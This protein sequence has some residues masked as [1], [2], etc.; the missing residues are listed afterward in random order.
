MEVRAMERA[1]PDPR[2]L[3]VTL[4]ILEEIKQ[5]I[6]PGS[7]VSVVVDGY[8]FD[9]DYHRSLWE[10]GYKVLI[11]DDKMN[12]PF[13]YGHVILNQNLGAEQFTYPSPENTRALLGSPYALIRP[14]FL[15]YRNWSRETS[16]RANRVLITMGGSDPDNVTLQVIQALELTDR[17]S[18]EAVVVIGPE[19]PHRKKLEKKVKGN[20]GR[21]RT[22]FNPDNL[23]ELMAWA[24]MAI[25]AA[26][27]TCWEL[28]F[29]MVPLLT[30]VLADNQEIVARGL[31][32]AGV[33]LNLGDFR[34]LGKET[35]SEALERLRNDDQGRREMSLRGRRFINGEGAREV[36][37]IFSEI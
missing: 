20:R 10:Q 3:E 35:L 31:S 15:A 34:R 25:S 37:R 30:L 12:L 23:P 28:S 32:E 22:I 33:G 17:D 21:V 36:V 4:K 1:H 9:E 11:V 29:M 18:I 26:G 19:N 27:S 2:D 8:H 6:T 16:K 24:D 14:E 7:D 13:Y 5:K